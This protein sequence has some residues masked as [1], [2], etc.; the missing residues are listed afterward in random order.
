MR[1]RSLVRTALAGGLLILSL[2]RCASTQQAQPAIDPAAPIASARLE[3]RLL[4][5]T[6][7][8]G[9]P[10]AGTMAL[11]L[12]ATLTNT[13]QETIVVTH[14]LGLIGE[15]RVAANAEAAR[16]GAWVV[17]PFPVGHVMHA[18]TPSIPDSAL[19]FLKPGESTSAT[20]DGWI[21]AR[22]ARNTG[23]AA[24]AVGPGSYALQITI[25]LGGG[26]QVRKRLAGKGTYLIGVLASEP[27]AF[28]F[29]DAD[30]EKKCPPAP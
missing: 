5:T 11:R 7:C 28:A 20:L 8:Q 13:S 6:F 17:E 12:E 24:W 14:G 16:R 4:G 2:P 1:R 22:T 23:A 25:G 18:G 3:T 27:M 19:L 15:A 10:D 26:E 30:V 29:P 9:E 21:K